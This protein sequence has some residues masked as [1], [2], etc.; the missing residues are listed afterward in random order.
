MADLKKVQTKREGDAPA[1][2]QEQE[3]T[4]AKKPVDKEYT[5]TVVQDFDGAVD[6][7]YLNKSDPNYKYRWLRIDDKNIVLKT[8]AL[9]T[10]GQGKVKFAQVGG[11]QIVPKA[12]LIRVGICN[13]K[14]LSPDG[15]LT[16]GGDLVLAF[17]PM[18]LWKS[19]EEFQRSKADAPANQIMN[20][21]ENGDPNVGL[22]ISSGKS[23]LKGIQT[24]EQLG[25]K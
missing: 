11:W 4:A 12:H 7:T 2:V 16:R 3:N 21:L 13:E 24:K 1:E 9:M 25:I 14:Q 18:D 6:L 5:L 23:R 10:D 15:T 20:L 8:S 19:K 17:M 22:D